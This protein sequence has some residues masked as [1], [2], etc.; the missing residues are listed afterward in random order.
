MPDEMDNEFEAT[1]RQQQL[2]AVEQMSL[3]NIRQTY[4]PEELFVEVSEELVFQDQKISS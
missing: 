4:D 1:L 3:P 2:A